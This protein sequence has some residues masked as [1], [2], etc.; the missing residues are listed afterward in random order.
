MRLIFHSRVGG[1]SHGAATSRNPLFQKPYFLIE[2]QLNSAGRR[3]DSP[4]EAAVYARSIAAL[5]GLDAAVRVQE[6]RL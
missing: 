4:P 2:G 1:S 3:L 5:D 6:A